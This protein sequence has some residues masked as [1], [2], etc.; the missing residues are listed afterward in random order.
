[1]DEGKK[2]IYDV[3]TLHLV[4]WRVHFFTAVH[5]KVMDAVLKMV[6]KQRHGE[7]IE[8]HQIKA[9]VDSFVSLGL[10]E[11]DPTK[12]T[13][14]VYR[15]SFEKP[16]LEATKV[17]YENESKQ[18]L[19]D[20]S[21]VEYMKKAEVRL[22][23]EDDRVKMYLHP[24][25][26][27]ALRK[28]C[29]TAMIANHSEVLREEFQ[30]LL[31]NDRIEDMQ[32]MYS[33][34]SKIHDGLEPL[35]AKFETHVR[36]A[37]QAAIN[38]V[39]ADADKIDPKVYVEALLEIHNQYEALVKKAFKDE[40]EFTRSLDNACKEF[41]N[42]N[43]VCKAGTNKSPELLAKYADS[44]LKKSATSVDEKDLEST[45]S[46]IMTV[47]KFIEDKDV[48]Q[49]FY[50]RMLA[51]RLVHTTSS[52]DDAETSM[53]SKLKEACGHEYTNKLQRMFQD[54][55]I[56]KD[57]NT[58]F[59]EAEQNLDDED[60][61]KQVDSS[62]NILGTASWPLQPPATKFV[63]PAEL[64]TAND[65]FTKFYSNKHQGRK[66]TW[67]WQLSKGEL[68]ANYIKTGKIPYTF[69]VSAYQMGVL[70]MFNENDTNSFEEISATT[71]VSDDQLIPSI[72]ILLKAKVLTS[73]GEKNGPG[74]VYNLNYDF[75]NK[76]IRV[77]LN[78]PIKADQKQE[79]EETHKTIE[80]D[81]KLLMQV[82]LTISRFLYH[83]NTNHKTVCHRPNHEGS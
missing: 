35:R 32:R 18:F 72:S 60:R 66:L 2:N 74:A 82:C 40:A 73:T 37:G 63:P 55:Q 14:E 36:N 7:T 10:D 1:M 16:F 25:I 3:Y 54:M 69:Q 21:I 5:K 31:D 48:F 49:K 15:F 45:L 68:K 4:E 28:T 80:E 83:V 57:L 13:L 33:L 24:D 11:A 59:K 58:S 46:Q 20:N 79:Q 77:N 76:K 38:K 12:S 71:E 52:S 41:V 47:F 23:E 34:L 64:V 9:I 27:E 50:S 8:H 65:R 43:S 29:N 42:R 44:L 22:N 62:Y 75:R 67:L 26:A 81:R 70:L 19:A 17:F 78:L 53:I 56:S 39:A 30:I 51:R 61:K 6:E